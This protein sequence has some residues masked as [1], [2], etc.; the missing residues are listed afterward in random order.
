MS[1]Q[2]NKTE[3]L[4]KLNRE[5]R[6]DKTWAENN[7]SKLLTFAAAT[8]QVSTPPPSS[9]SS[10]FGGSFGM[11]M[12]GLAV[13]ATVAA[14]AGYY[15]LA[16]EDVNE[17]QSEINNTASVIEAAS[18]NDVAPEE[19]EISSEAEMIEIEDAVLEEVLPEKEVVEETE[20]EIIIPESP[21]EKV[22]EEEIKEE[23]EKSNQGLHIG[24]EYEDPNTANVNEAKKPSNS[25]KKE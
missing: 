2:N 3:Y 6:V 12:I 20:V 7:K 14:G 9:G 11:S 23:K 15:L 16:K 24:T 8:P 25:K 13:A 18:N 1:N 10:L 19:N 17:E 21:T 22:V 5:I 4:R